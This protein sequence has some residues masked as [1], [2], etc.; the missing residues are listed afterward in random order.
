VF[1]SR[2]RLVAFGVSIVFDSQTRLVAFGSETQQFTFLKGIR[3]L[4][5][6]ATNRFE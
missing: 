6:I 3:K 4:G 5:E 2:K 1:D